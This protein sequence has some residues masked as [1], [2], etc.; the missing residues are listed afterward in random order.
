MLVIFIVII[1][2]FNYYSYYI[3]KHTVFGGREMEE[4]LKKERDTKELI[5][6]NCCEYYLHHVHPIY[7]DERIEACLSKPKIVGDY[8]NKKVRYD[9]PKEK[10][11]EMDCLEFCPKLKYRMRKWL[12]GSY[13]A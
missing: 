10:N 8:A 12:K 11:D 13:H 2:L 5:F 1:I 3:F 9:V 6:C 7:S 4:S